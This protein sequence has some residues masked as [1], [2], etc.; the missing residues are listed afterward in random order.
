MIYFNKENDSLK[1]YRE[2]SKEYTLYNIDF[3]NKTA[4]IEFYFD[5]SNQMVTYYQE[6]ISEAL[7]LVFVELEMKK[8]YVNVIR[9]NYQLLY[10]LSKFNFISEAIHR[11]QYFDVRPHDVVYMTVLNGEWKRG[12]IR[13]NFNYDRYDIKVTDTQTFM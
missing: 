8:I 1:P 9:D 2:Y 12:G 13:Y 6:I 5:Y 4:G 7:Q 3:F 11:E 10:I